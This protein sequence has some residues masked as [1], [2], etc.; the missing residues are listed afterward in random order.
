M[1]YNQKYLNSLDRLIKASIVTENADIIA[2]C[3]SDPSE[4][5]FSISKNGASVTLLYTNQSRDIKKDVTRALLDIITDTQ[6]DNDIYG[7]IENL[8]DAVKEVH[9]YW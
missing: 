5:V 7:K 8:A 9:C 2:I 3:P 1:K 6:D 4:G